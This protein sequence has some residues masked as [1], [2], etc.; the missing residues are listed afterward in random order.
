MQNIFTKSTADSRVSFSHA[1]VPEDLN[2]GGHVYGAR[3][4]EWADNLSAV[5]AISHRRGGVTTASFDQFDFIR[6]IKL[7]DFVHA[8]G[9]ISGTGPH[10]MEIFIKFIGEDSVTGDR[11]LAAVTF[12]TYAARR[13]KEGE[14]VPGIVGDTEEEK[15][16]IA[17]YEG[18]R[19]RVKEKIARNQALFTAI[20]LEKD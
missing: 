14:V 9:F 3:L 17:G 8:K 10:S 16:I 11:Y 12:I 1:T 6:P 13:L 20:N 18:R 7:G 2:E 19:M 15:T 5:I 4:L